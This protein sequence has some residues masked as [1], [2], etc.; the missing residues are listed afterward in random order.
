MFVGQYIPRIMHIVY[1]LSP[2]DFTHIPQ[3]GFTG[4][5]AI[6]RLRQCQWRNP[7]EYG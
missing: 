5:G 3:D 2:V 1:A 7:D 4:T 6:L